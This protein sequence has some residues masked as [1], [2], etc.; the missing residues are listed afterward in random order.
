MFVASLQCAEGMTV[1]YCAPSDAGERR[2][3][4]WTAG[5]LAHV[6]GRRLQRRRRAWAVAAHA[7]AKRL[8]AAA[9]SGEPARASST[10]CSTGRRHR[11]STTDRSTSRRQTLLDGL[12]LETAD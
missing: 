11:R 5:R 10:S 12:T 6:M 8:S 9:R 7:L 3:Q 4:P 1:H 2:R